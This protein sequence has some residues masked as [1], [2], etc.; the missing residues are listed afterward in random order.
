MK[1]RFFKI[2]TISLSIGVI[3]LSTLS[4]MLPDILGFRDM[5]PIIYGALILIFALIGIRTVMEKKTW[6]IVI[7]GITVVMLGLYIGNLLK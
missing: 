5:Y 2:I 4:I 7:L 1:N 6:G 3:V